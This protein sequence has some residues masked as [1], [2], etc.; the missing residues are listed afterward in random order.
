VDERGTVTAMAWIRRLA[1]D[2]TALVSVLVVISPIWLGPAIGAL[3]RTI[4]APTHVCACGM[5]MGKCGCAACARLERQRA[6]DRGSLSGPILKSTCDDWS[7]AVPSGP[8]LACILQAAIDLPASTVE[9]SLRVPAFAHRF[10]R[11]GEGPPT[12]PPRESLL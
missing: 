12:P 5:P 8:P 6:S 7:A 9:A 2:V 1:R 3:S 11:M 10:S 4:G